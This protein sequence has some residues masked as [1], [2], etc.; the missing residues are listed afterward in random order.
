MTEEQILKP[1]VPIAIIRLDDLTDAVSIS[2]ALAAGGIF[3][4]EYTLTNRRALDAVREV[5]QAR[6]A[7]E[8]P[9]ELAV[10]V[11]TVLD[12]A[13]ARASLDSGAQFL[14]TPVVSLEVLAEARAENAPVVCGAMTPTEIWTAS[15]AG[16]AFIKVFSARALGPAYLRDVLGPLPGLRFIPTG[17]ISLEN[18]AAFLAAGAYSVG[19]GGSLVSAEAVRHRDWE[20]ITTN[21]R[22]FV[23]AC[24][25]IAP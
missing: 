22:Q 9:E 20:A 1:R 12:A 25:G 3:A 13:A 18:C 23:E 19:I 8:L 24:A 21:A 14:V 6:D 17:G 4:Q 10:G 7:G 2:R 11:G 16:A 5:C 15:R